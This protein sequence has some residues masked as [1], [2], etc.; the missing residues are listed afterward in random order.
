[1]AEWFE[2]YEDAAGR[3]ASR[4]R[5]RQHM[6]VFALASGAVVAGAPLAAFAWPAWS[7]AAAGVA[8][9]LLGGHAAFVVWH[10]ARIRR[11]V[12]RLD[13][14]VHH[15]VGHDASGGRRVLAW[16][17]V[18][19]VDLS[20]AGIDIV[21]RRMGRRVRLVVPASFPDHGRVGH[22]VVRYAEAFSRPVFVDG[23]PWQSLGIDTLLPDPRR[24][25]AGPRPP[26]G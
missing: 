8:G 22:R 6:L 3:R 23:R 13:L 25:R 2:V 19:W 21:G 4:L 7:V 11:T 9:V 26:A 10:L 5:A 18:T 12:W 15:V 14:S 16:A 1:M 20:D 24:H 17:D